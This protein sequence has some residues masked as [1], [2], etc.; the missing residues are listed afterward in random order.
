MEADGLVK[1]Q[2]LKDTAPQ[3]VEYRLTE[4]GKTLQ[5]PLSAICTWAAAHPPEPDSP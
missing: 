1:R 4:L 2:V 5:D 3:H